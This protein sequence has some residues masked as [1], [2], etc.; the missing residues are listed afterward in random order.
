MP[1]SALPPYVHTYMLGF[2]YFFFSLI[3]QVNKSNKSNNEFTACQYQ[4]C[5]FS[6]MLFLLYVSIENIDLHV[7]VSTFSPFFIILSNVVI[8]SL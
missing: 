2:F 7:P 6:S 5:F 8:G 3:L 1:N 4:E